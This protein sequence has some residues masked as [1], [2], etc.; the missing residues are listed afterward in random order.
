MLEILKN[1][2]LYGIIIASLL[3]A[4]VLPIPMET[5]SIPAYLSAKENIIYLLIILV[6]FSTLG[7]IVGYSIWKRLGKIIRNKYREKDIFIKIKILYERN[8]FLTLLSS[9]F[10]PIPFEAYVMVAGILSINF[11]LFLIGVVLSRILRHFPQG[12]LIY[13]YGDKILDNIKLYSF[14]IIMF[15]FSFNLVKYLILKKIK[16]SDI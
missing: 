10:T 4:T 8:I 2:G 6:S 7:S 12:L 3:E 1:Y 14:L 11:K 13:F 16:A 9:A 15:I 5:I